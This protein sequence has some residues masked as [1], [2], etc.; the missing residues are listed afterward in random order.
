[1][2]LCGNVSTLASICSPAPILDFSPPTPVCVCV[3]QLGVS[4]RWRSGVSLPDPGTCRPD[5]VLFEVEGS[6]SEPVAITQISLGAFHTG[7][8][9]SKGRLWTF[10]KEVR[11]HA[12]TLPPPPSSSS[13]SELQL[14]SDAASGVMSIPAC[15]RALSY[16]LLASVS[17]VCLLLLADGC[18]LQDYGTLGYTV[19]DGD[20]HYP[21]LVEGLLGERVLSVRGHWTGSLWDYSR[22]THPVATPHSTCVAARG[23]CCL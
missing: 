21:R 14:L 8:V 22:W 9:D 5:R 18:V 19:E 23:L 3:C 2:T 10:G 1:M 11:V 17:I 12:A 13:R 6:D 16:S 15:M 4:D 7:C 20:Q